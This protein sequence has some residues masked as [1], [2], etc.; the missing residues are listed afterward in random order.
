MEPPS[1]ASRVPK[2]PCHHSETLVKK[3]SDT[4]GLVGVTLREKHVT[5]EHER[6]AFGPQN[7]CGKLGMVAR[8]WSPSSQ[9]V[10]D[11]KRAFGDSA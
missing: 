8:S 3:L 11:R 1:L 9:R 5:R 2:F 10:K 7:P 6:P 4:Q